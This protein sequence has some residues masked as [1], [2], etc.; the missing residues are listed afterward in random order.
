MKQENLSSKVYS[1]DF[2]TKAV[3][4]DVREVD[5]FLDE[6]KQNE[7]ELKKTVSFIEK[8]LE[9]LVSPTELEVIKH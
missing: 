8:E 4:Y 2:S 6:L 7:S 1:K 3:G 9:K 5:N